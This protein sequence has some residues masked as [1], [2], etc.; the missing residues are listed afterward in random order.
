MVIHL[1]RLYLLDLLQVLLTI[2]SSNN[3]SI[4]VAAIIAYSDGVGLN[5]TEIS[6]SID[7]LLINISDLRSCK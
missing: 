6:C 2:I 1:L 3:T 7:T 4:N 5:G